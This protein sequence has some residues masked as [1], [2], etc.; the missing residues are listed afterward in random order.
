MTIYNAD[1]IKDG[2]MEF[3]KVPKNIVQNT[4]KCFNEEDAIGTCMSE[5]YENF[6]PPNGEKTYLLFNQLKSLVV[7]NHSVKS[8]KVTPHILENWLLKNGFDIERP[9]SGA[10]DIYRKKKC[11]VNVR[12]TG[13]RNDVEDDGDDSYIIYEEDTGNK[14]N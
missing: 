4:Q 14:K 3:N 8:K 9:T 1:K 10:S 7:E 12:T 5:N 11:L 13:N 2:A 6:V